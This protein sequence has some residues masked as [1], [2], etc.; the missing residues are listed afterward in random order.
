MSISSKPS[1]KNNQKVISTEQLNNIQAVAKQTRRGNNI[2]GRGIEV[3]ETTGE[4]S[5]IILEAVP[6]LYK[7]TGTAVVDGITYVK[8]KEVDSAT[9]D[10]YGSELYFSMISL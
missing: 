10:I 8:G 6:I 4:T 5:D 7:T 1:F 2:V 3:T 9:G